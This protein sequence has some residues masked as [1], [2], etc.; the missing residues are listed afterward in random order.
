VTVDQEKQLTAI[1]FWKPA[2]DTGTHLGRD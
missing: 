2:S 1:R